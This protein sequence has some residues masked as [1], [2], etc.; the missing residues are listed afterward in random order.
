MAYFTTTV[1][2]ICESLLGY[3]EPQGYSQIDSIVTNSAP[4]LFDFDFPI[5]DENYRLTLE[6]KILKHY[7]MKEIGAETVGLW[8]LW[9]DEKLNLIM[10]Y[11]NQL[12]KT[13][14]YEFNPLYEV[15][16]TTEHEGKGKTDR[17]NFNN[18]KNQEN[19]SSTRDKSE[20]SNG[21]D[22]NSYNRTGSNISKFSD[23]PQGSIKDL[24]ND[25]YLT[26]ATID[27][28][29]DK[30]SSDNKRSDV[31]QD[32]EKIGTKLD[33][34]RAIVGR[35]NISNTDEYVQ[36]VFGTNGGHTYASKILEYRKTLLN[37][38]AM[39]IEELNE[40]F[41]GLWGW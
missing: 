30:A 27:N 16:L 39:I 19:R 28:S 8:K 22:S 11:Y 25:T 7:Y 41:F 5:W 15:D 14:T 34:N 12:Y 26:N 10:P 24:A 17:A 4:L 29:T 3:E 20:I 23:T 6:K 2:T 38:D 1:R 35:E 13:T 9:L 32:S 40:L 18:E 31:K 33:G 36:H 37:I 21:R